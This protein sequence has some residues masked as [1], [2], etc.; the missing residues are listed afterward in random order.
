MRAVDLSGS[1][2][3]YRRWHEKFATT[4]ASSVPLRHD[5]VGMSLYAKRLDRGR[6]IWPS[7]TDGVAAIIAD[8]PQNRLNELLPWNWRTPPA[9]LEAP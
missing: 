5:G 3:R 6:L 8:M 4:V 2:A 1:A 9:L 7:A